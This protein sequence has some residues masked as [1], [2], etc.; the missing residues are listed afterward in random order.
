MSGKISVLFVVIVFSLY[1]S[2]ITAQDLSRVDSLK[3][4]L[5]TVK[6]DTG[7]VNI[8]NVLGE[9]FRYGKENE[10]EIRY[11]NEAILLAQ[12]I[13]DKKGLVNAYK[14]LGWYN[15]SR[16]NYADALKNFAECLNIS[17]KIGYQNG[18][19]QG[20]AGL[21]DVHCT[22]GNYP[23]SLEYFSKAL[24]IFR[25]TF[26]QK[27]ITDVYA[28]IGNIYLGKG[29]YPV[30]LDNYMSGLKVAEEIGDKTRIAW[31]Y[32][33]VALIYYN[34]R[35]YSEALEYYR[36]VLGIGNEIHDKAM[37][38][39]TSNNIGLI[40]ADQGEYNEALKYYAVSVKIT[41]E[42]GDQEVLAE[43]IMNIGEIYLQQGDYTN[44]LKNYFAALKMYEGLGLR[45]GMGMTFIGIGTVISKQ[46]IHN[47]SDAGSQQFNEAIHYLNMGLSIARQIGDK[48][49]LKN[50]FLSLSETER[51][52]GNYK[53]ALDDY[54]LFFIYHDSLL[55]EEGNNKVTRLK[56]SNETEKRDR[57][58]K[59]L[60]KEN[61][62]KTL[63]VKQQRILVLASFA[64]ITLLI[65]I[66][67]F[68][69]NSRRRLN[70]AFLL[71]NRK[72]KVIETTLEKLKQTQSQLIQSEKMASL[73]MLTAGIAHEIN[74]PVNFINSGA[75]S[76]Q[77]DHEDL[78]QFIQS[79]E[80][81][82]PG[83]QK[84]A[85]EQGI[86]E[87]L[88][89]MPQTID[90]IMTGVTRTSEI[91]NGLR[92][93]TRVDASEL[94]ET[95]IHE[96]L[97]ATLLLLNS[98]IKDRITVVKEFDE[99][100]GFIKC[101]PGPLNQVFMNLL[102]NAIEAIDQKITN[103]PA[104]DQKY[105]IGITTSLMETGLQK[106]VQ[107]K[108]SDNGIGIPDEI[109]DKLFDPFFTT[110]DV[111]KGT[112][113]GLSICHGIIKKHDG[114]ISFESKVNEGSAFTIMLPAG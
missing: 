71:V 38:A 23:L 37:I 89:Y 51:I 84:Y 78:K 64:G 114:S 112:G 92:N 22:L 31:G 110:K 107:I 99:R 86:D 59:L 70:R 50:G 41:E 46:A 9:R 81:K 18:I 111:G 91:I 102:N 21:A 77:K 3:A 40:Y 28:G 69:I 7:K 66:V 101:Y 104:A 57:E 39:Y 24:R 65:I 20:Y 94:K 67:L 72:N 8:L 47:K 100:I 30:A 4:L 54:Q 62:I 61:E 79:L 63:Q 42:L 88:A 2:V 45:G 68:I 1:S 48:K 80:Y 53:K 27:G 29:N 103:C 75:I 34:L 49:S 73:G 52:Q 19:A 26:N 74:N 13:N 58:I 82:F 44:A 105:Q 106:Q 90:D 17:I 10:T 93:F 109:K 36:K 5:K 83:V 95:N 98:K 12:K 32:F 15:K 55:S 76:L 97:E 33:S 113:L 6:E 16:G 87:I 35:N 96:G 108:I 56:I 25:Q 43:S 60:G 85:E 14:S 11:V